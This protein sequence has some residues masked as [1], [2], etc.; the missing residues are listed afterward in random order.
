M[1]GLGGK[2]RVDS[3]RNADCVD[4]GKAKDRLTGGQARDRVYG[5]K[6]RDVVSGDGGTDKLVGGLGNDFISA[7][8][9]AGGTVKAGRGR[10]RINVA[11]SGVATKVWGGKQFD[12][13]YCNRHELPKLHGV[14]KTKLVLG[15]LQ[16][17]PGV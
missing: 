4:G 2:D 12:L 3:G 1:L 17:R 11:T 6:A 9:G 14:E 7:G 5:G 15:P 8:Y 10:D 16:H 13:V